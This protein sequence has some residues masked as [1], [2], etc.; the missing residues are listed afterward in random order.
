M[1]GSVINKSRPWVRRPF[2]IKRLEKPM[3]L[4]RCNEL[5]L[6]AGIAIGV[7]FMAA[8]FG[9]IEEE[10]SLSRG[11]FMDSIGLLAIAYLVWAI[12]KKIEARYSLV[13][14]AAESEVADA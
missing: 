10:P 5:M 8:A 6:G 4:R 12:R 13:D 3:T 9:V 2:W 1:F 11:A 7:F 14:T